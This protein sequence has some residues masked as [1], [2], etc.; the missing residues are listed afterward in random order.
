VAQIMGLLNAGGFSDIGLVTDIA[1]P[2]P[3]STDG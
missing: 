2:A 3:D 1:G